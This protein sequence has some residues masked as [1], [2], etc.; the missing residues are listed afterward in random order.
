MYRKI[1]GNIKDMFSR[2]PISDERDESSGIY[3]EKD[4]RDLL[5]LERKRACRSGKQFMLVCLDMRRLTAKKN[6]N[7][8]RPI[9]EVVKMAT[10]DT[11]IK[12]WYLTSKVLGIIYTEM[13]EY[14]ESF[15]RSKLEHELLAVIN[16]ELFREIS[17]D[18]YLYPESGPAGRGGN[19]E[20]CLMLYPDIISVERPGGVPLDLKRMVDIAGSML[21]II[22]FLP[23][24]LLI[25]ILVKIT[26]RG[27]VFF[28]QERVGQ[29]GRKFTFLKFRTMYTNCDESIHRSYIH[30]LIKK[31]KSA[32]VECSEGKE[33]HVFK[34]KNDPR[35]TPLG[36]WLR[37]SSM[38]E[39]PQFIN[40]LKGDMSL[41][42]PRPPIPYELENYEV[43][44]LRRVLEVK[45]GITGLW[46][47]EGR[48]S[49]TFDEMVRMDLRYIRKRT[50]L[51]DLKLIMRTP[52]AVL[53]GKGAY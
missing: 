25:P 9:V 23:L 28:R 48:S 22:L 3:S 33:A 26:S 30:E 31:G 27:P 19:D 37:K 38:D 8:S 35:V 44:H 11:D 45:P 10:R 20:R 53:K 14:D 42:G 32:A 40:V 47:V 17:I 5:I 36:A 21:G 24:F 16:Q 51:L 50:L 43:W 1:I 7:H 18:C 2:K 52:L 46:Q 29:Y 13:S 49:T 34:I 41:V 6:G 15:I 12:G 4:F 39:L